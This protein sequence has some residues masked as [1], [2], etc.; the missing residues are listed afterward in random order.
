MGRSISKR[1]TKKHRT[2]KSH[3]K[4]SHNKKRS[5]KC[6][7]GSTLV[8]LSD[9]NRYCKKCDSIVRFGVPAVMRRPGLFGHKHRGSSKKGKGRG[10]G[11]RGHKFGSGE[12]GAGYPGNDY[13]GTT[14]DYFGNNLMFINAP[15]WWYP[16]VDQNGAEVGASP[17]M[18]K[19]A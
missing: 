16:A 1:V 4:K 13:P 11:R 17:Q 12:Y 18:L 19:S 10:K 7:C 9:G 2:K 3:H 15:K 5:A 6:V 8:K 14:T